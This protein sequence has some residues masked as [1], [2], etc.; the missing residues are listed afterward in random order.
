ML[1]ATKTSKKGSQNTPHLA[2]GGSR[3]AN[4]P[5]GNSRA[6][7][8]RRGKK[9]RPPNPTNDDAL[10]GEK[11]FFRV[12]TK[13]TRSFVSCNSREGQVGRSF[14]FKAKGIANLREVCRPTLSGSIDGS[15]NAL[16]GKTDLSHLHSSGKR[17]ESGDILLQ[18]DPLIICGSCDNC[19][20][21]IHIV[22]G[23]I[24]AIM[25]R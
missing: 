4:S 15:L 2:V 21:F 14:F 9:R 16:S 7:K 18:E 1:S 6:K 12:C 13:L 22:N 11:N 10:I 3:A 5:L 24:G 17:K 25:P 8:C 19:R 20:T 23:K